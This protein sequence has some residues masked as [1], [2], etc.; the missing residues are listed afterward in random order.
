[1]KFGYI[2]NQILSK[3]IPS[4][5]LIFSSVCIKGTVSNSSPYYLFINYKN[6]EIMQVININ[7]NNDNNNNNNI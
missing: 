2:G 5:W 3:I 6:R 7:D 1:M 4:N